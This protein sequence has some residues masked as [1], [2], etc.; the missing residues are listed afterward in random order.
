MS[1]I[2]AF[3]LGYALGQGATKSDWEETVTA[4][5]EIL[6]SAEAQALMQSAAQVGGQVAQS[7]MSM[8]SRQLENSGGGSGRPVRVA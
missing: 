3:A 8:V 2:I 5:R 7:G 6:N 1:M 4:L